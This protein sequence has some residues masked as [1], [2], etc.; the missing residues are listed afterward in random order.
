MQKV[1]PREGLGTLCRLFGYSRQ[2]YYQRQKRRE[3]AQIQTGIIVDEVEQIREKI[4]RIGGRKLFFMLKDKLLA[5]GIKIGRDKF[6]SVLRV[7]DLLIKPRKKRVMTTMS[8]HY[9]RKYPNLIK[10]LI[11]DAPNHLWVSD[12]TYI[13]VKDK[14]H[15]VIFITDAYSKTVVGYNV[16]EKADA[17]FCVQAL[18]QALEQWTDRQHPLIH[19]SDRGVQYCSFAYTGKLKDNE[20]QISMTQSGDPLENAIAE[21]VNGIF[22]TD[23]LMDRTFTSLQEAEKEILQMV[24]NYNNLRPHASC[25]YFT[26]AQAHQITGT[27]AKRW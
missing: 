10:D 12:I 20:I 24:D 19:H 3:K 25:D 15:Y 18:E 7:N 5:H 13:K 16:S 17:A 23:F 9:L 2:A 14:W 27:L 21:R 22:K 4:A 8:K 1:Y 6:F 11:V 26:P